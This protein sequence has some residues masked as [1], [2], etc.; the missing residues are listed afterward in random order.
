MKMQSINHAPKQGAV[1]QHERSED[2]WCLI[3]VS[4]ERRAWIRYQDLEEVIAN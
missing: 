1:V 4:S 2:G 3:H